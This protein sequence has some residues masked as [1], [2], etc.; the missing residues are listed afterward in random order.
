MRPFLLVCLVSLVLGASF[1]RPAFPRVGR[2]PPPIVRRRLLP[3]APTWRV[4]PLSFSPRIFY[5]HNFL[6][7][8]ECRHLIDVA[9][10]RLARSTVVD[11]AGGGR[12]DEVRNSAGTFLRRRSDD[13]IEGI[14]NRLSLITMIP[15]E[16]QE[17]MQVL[18]YE[19]GQHY[20]PH[21]DWFSGSAEKS[22]EN[23]LQRI[24]T[25]LIFL[26][27]D[28]EGGET[29]FPLVE[30]PA[31][32]KDEGMSACAQKSLALKPIAG[33]AVLFWT[34]TPD[35]T[36]DERTTHGSC[37]VVSGVKYSAPI[38]NRQKPFHLSDLA[39]S[40]PKVCS[41]LNANCGTWATNGECTKNNLYM[42]DS[43]AKSCGLCPPQPP[44]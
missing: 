33:D 39:P 22:A 40:G 15:V 26:N 4:E 37:G 23:G 9:T 10:P 35:G 29:I 14:E 18:R 38:W 5:I 31:S 17:D 21:N 7:A 3:A 12:V 13:V 27:D 32:Q 8:S 30:K 20:L 19:V 36:E 25:I 28:F 6:N 11:G 2:A 34:L 1:P 41:D 24:A 16:H 43:C 42:I 44:V